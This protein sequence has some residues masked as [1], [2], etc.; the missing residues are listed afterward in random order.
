MLSR[1]PS[2]GGTPRGD[3]AVGSVPRRAGGARC[4]LCAAAAASPLALGVWLPFA[5]QLL[6]QIAALCHCFPNTF[7]ELEK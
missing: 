6:M 7:P 4:P 5:W 2:E 1:R 3:L